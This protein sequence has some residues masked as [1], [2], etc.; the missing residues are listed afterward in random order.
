MVRVSRYL[1]ELGN[2]VATTP[3]ICDGVDTDARRCMI[4]AMASVGQSESLN[5]HLLVDS[6]PALIHT[7]RPD[8]YLDYF[9]K[10]WLD[11]LGAT[12][13]DV[14]GWKWESLR[15]S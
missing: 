1:L 2:Y 3:M 15:S 5:I 12:L 10:P 8:G 6:I 13:D 14:T 11:Y 9:N 7:A 4:P